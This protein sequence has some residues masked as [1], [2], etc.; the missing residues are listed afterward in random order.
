MIT[1]L[2]HFCRSQWLSLLLLSENSC[3]QPS[4]KMQ[5]YLFYQ[6]E[7]KC[8][9][10]VSSQSLPS[11][12]DSRGVQTSSSRGKNE[13]RSEKDKVLMPT[14]FYLGSQFSWRG[15][16]IPDRYS[17]GSCQFPSYTDRT[18]S[19]WK[20]LILSYFLATPTFSGSAACPSSFVSGAK[21]LGCWFAP[22]LPSYKQ[23]P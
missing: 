7:N 10:R 5:E 13:S 11:Q 23:S 2:T 20:D 4:H 14:C 22:W 16:G 3:F 19:N 18:R 8:D 6:E 17:S 1:S 12:Q 15:Q 9:W 21:E